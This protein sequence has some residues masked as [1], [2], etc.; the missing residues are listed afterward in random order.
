MSTLRSS[1]EKI[2]SREAQLLE[3]MLLCGYG[4]RPEFDS[5]GN[6]YWPRRNPLPRTNPLNDDAQF[7]DPE[8]SECSL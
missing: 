4:Y 8:L 1:E 3:V 5:S 7:D 6:L 2:A